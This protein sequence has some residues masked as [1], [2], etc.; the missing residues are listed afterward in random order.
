M[1][2]RHSDW[3]KITSHFIIK[4]SLPFY[5]SISKYRFHLFSDLFGIIDGNINNES[6]LVWMKL[7]D[8]VNMPMT[9]ERHVSFRPLQR[10]YDAARAKLQNN[11]I[12]LMASYHGLRH[13]DCHNISILS[14]EHRE[15]AALYFTGEM[16][17]WR[18]RRIVARVLYRR[19]LRQHIAVLP[20]WRPCTSPSQALSIA[21]IIRICPIIQYGRHRLN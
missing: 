19:Y 11:A 21:A 5:H 12:S 14:D 8:A 16:K 3:Y 17:M 7:S 13:D 4:I 10:E 20:L 1:S 18:R 15:I 2:L 9:N 6:T